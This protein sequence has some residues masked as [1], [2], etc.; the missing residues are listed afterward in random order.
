MPSGQKRAQTR[1][2][3][4]NLPQRVGGRWHVKN[5]K[6]Q[7]VSIRRPARLP[8][9][10]RKRRKP[11]GVAPIAPCQIE[12]RFLHIHHLPPIRRQRSIPRGNILKSMSRPPGTGTTHNG[13]ATAGCS[14]PPTNSSDRALER[15]MSCGSSNGTGIRAVSPPASD[16]SA[17]IGASLEPSVKYTRLP[18]TKIAASVP[19][20]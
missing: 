1:S 2:V 12:L 6:P 4:R 11:S 17:S 15:S 19:P 16:T 8:A 9:A 3:T 13:G 18:S 14:A 20:I 10:S 7:S 5:R